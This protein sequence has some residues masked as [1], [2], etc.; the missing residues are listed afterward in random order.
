[1]KNN[2]YLRLSTQNLARNRRGVLP[3]AISCIGTVMVFFILVTLVYTPSFL[4]VYGRRTIQRTLEMGIYVMVLFSLFFLF[5]TNSFLVKRRK[6]EFGLLNILGLEKRHLGRVMLLET[7]ILGAVTTGLGMLLGALLSKLMFLLLIR[8]IGG[9]Q[10]YQLVI[11]TRAFTLV[12]LVFGAV[13]LL[14]LFTSLLTVHLN[15]PINLLKGENQGEKEPK[16]RLF[17]GLM[18]AFGVISLGLGYAIS[19]STTDP[20]TS[21][22]LFM[23]A[24]LLVV[25]GTYALFAAG[26]VT[27]L[28]AL[29]R[30]KRFYYKPENFSVIGG[31]IHR[32]HRNAVGLATICILSTMVL[33]M[34][35]VSANLYATREKDLALR[36]PKD[37]IIKAGPVRDQKQA[38]DFLRVVSEVAQEHGSKVKQPLS[39]FSLALEGMTH[40]D[41]S[42]ISLYDQTVTYPLESHSLRLRAVSHQALLPLLKE[43]QALKPGEALVYCQNENRLKDQIS[44]LGI[45]LALKEVKDIGVL[46]QPHM[47]IT[48]EYLLFLHEDDLSHLMKL[49]LEAEAHNKEMDHDAFSYQVLFDMDKL[50]LEQ[51]R[52]FADQVQTRLADL[53]F[54]NSQGVNTFVNHVELDRAEFN[55]MLGGL[56]FV[57]LFLGLVFIMAMVLIIYYKQVSEGLEDQRRYLIM[58]QVGMSQQEV[59]KSTRRQ[60]LLVFFLPL[61]MAGLHLAFS[62]NITYRVFYELMR[63][64][65]LFYA[66]VTALCY[67]AFAVFYAFVYLKTAGTY[68]RLVKSQTN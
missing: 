10:L 51:A 15:N 50:S 6:K 34:V 38:A 37:A 22:Q 35:S 48:R 14:T 29:R 56:L 46:S 3:Y 49:M 64:E 9:T 67:L 61:L 7:L 42:R 53:L 28:R 23:I 57:A 5:Y 16:G 63:G 19:L 59:Q 68:Y 43:S 12:P 55:A 4:E 65:F 2:L 26:S 52:D 8:M 11:P 13:H 32:M 54:L 40:E 47:G 44:L 17:L 33:V 31:M 21:M 41:S 39:F 30:R 45:P 25:L 60:V 66:G 1:M 27:L 20:L 58:Q 24:V 62:L 18:A 36:Y